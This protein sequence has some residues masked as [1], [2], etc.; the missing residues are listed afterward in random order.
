MQSRHFITFFPSLSGAVGIA[1]VSCMQISGYWSSHPGATVKVLALTA[2]TGLFGIC[3]TLAQLV[4]TG[5]PSLWVASGLLLSS[6]ELLF[7]IL[8]TDMLYVWYSMGGPKGPIQ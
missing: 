7:A 5:R 6:G 1:V 3:L 2:A 4:R 8:T